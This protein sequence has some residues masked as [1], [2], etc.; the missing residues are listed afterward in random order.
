MPEPR[1]ASETWPVFATELV[2][3]HVHERG[4]VVFLAKLGEKTCYPTA[5]P[6][7]RRQPGAPL[8]SHFDY[9]G[10]RRDKS[11]RIFVGRLFRIAFVVL[12]A[13]SYQ[14]EHKS[15]LSADWAHLPI[16]RDAKLFD[17]L[18]TAGKR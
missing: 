6:T 12:H 18:V 5:T 15:A 1:K 8:R 11:A 9:K 3:L 4:S 14:A 13:P 7:F 10:E 17:R 16:P 2:D